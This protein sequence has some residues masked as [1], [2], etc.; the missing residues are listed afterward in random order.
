MKH[1]ILLVD[2]EPVIVEGLRIL[3]ETYLAHVGKIF[4]A[5]SGEEG[6]LQAREN[7]PD[8][9][10]SDIRM[11]G[12]DGLEMIRQIKASGIS[13]HFI[14]VSGYE[15]FDYA[16][17]AISLGVEEYL[18]K[19]VEEEELIS[20]WNKI[21]GKIEEKKLSENSAF[22]VK[23]ERN[24]REY[25]QHKEEQL[26]QADRNNAES[27]LRR[28]HLL[29]EIPDFEKIR[30]VVEKVIPEKTYSEGSYI[31]S[32]LAVMCMERVQSNR[33]EMDSLSFRYL[34]KLNALDAM[35]NTNQLKIF[36]KEII[37]S[38]QKTM[39]DVFSVSGGDVIT[40][41]KEY[42]KLN[43]A[44]NISLQDISDHF[45]INPTYLSE[46][47]KKR[48]GMTYKNYLIMVRMN[49]AR[50]LLVDTDL[51]IYEICEAVG[52][53]DVN[54]LNRMFEREY[55]MK[56]SEYRNRSGRSGR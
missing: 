37:N 35:K 18:T 46:L 5:Y 28:I 43:S 32:R 19:P 14:L 51:R 16:K 23:G 13:S 15:E 53:T 11:T 1:S 40:A 8:V 54:H 20:A 12:I 10:I 33:K 38:T 2:D 9:I 3:V 45:F 39:E 36:A 22:D 50:K 47:F 52:Y 48:T 56:M 7:M 24:I 17:T 34:A 31:V 6:I 29:L 55:G 4:M 26:S 49:K 30:H 21:I 25:V 41:V 44:R 27:F 42:I